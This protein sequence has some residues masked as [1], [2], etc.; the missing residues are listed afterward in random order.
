M[1]RSILLLVF[2]LVIAI[3]GMQAVHS[4]LNWYSPF[5][6]ALGVILLAALLQLPP[7]HDDV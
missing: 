6:M 1:Q 3:T 5:L 7:R 4:L 2:I